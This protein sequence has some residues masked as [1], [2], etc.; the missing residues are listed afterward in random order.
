ML[1]GLSAIVVACGGNAEGH[2]VPELP[3]LVL[4]PKL[5]VFRELAATGSQPPTEKRAAELEDLFKTAFA[6]GSGSRLRTMA[7][8]SLLDADD[9]FW[10]LEQ[11]LEQDDANMRSIAAHEL[12]GLGHQ[13]S[14]LPLLK[15]LKY[16]QDPA[17]LVWVAASLTKLGNHAGLP[18]LVS[19]MERAGTAPQ[20]GL[21]AIEILK[22]LGIATGVQPTYGQLKVWLRDQHRKW[23]HTGT[24]EGGKWPAKPDALTAARIAQH[25][26]RLEDFQLRP[27]D[28]ARFV[29]VRAGVLS[30][31]LLAEA[32][33]A[34]EP[35]LRN[36]ALEIVRDLGRPARSLRPKI[37]PLLADPLSR[38]FAVQALGNI[39]ALE[40][41][42]HLL[43]MLH[44]PEAELRAAAA[45]ALGPLGSKDAI[46]PLKAVLADEKEMMDVR[47]RAA[48]SL[49]IFELERPA[50]QFLEERKAKG[51]YHGSTI[52]ELMNRVEQQRQ[53]R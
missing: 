27:V 28:D 10:I 25:L 7:K 34:N 26:T 50:F 43:A 38:S 4:A 36:H 47:V 53:D 35:Y 15:R 1:A 52:D 6:P 51:D 44:S 45:E 11:G 30:L 21:Q 17:V 48:F 41:L 32:V 31:D 5:P 20:A 12:G 3:P 46:A 19:L 42:P 13:A 23:R 33:Q 29:L 18:K 37:L 8:R 2:E 9:A 22:A 49:A 39:G 40:A 24:V 14:I 16:E